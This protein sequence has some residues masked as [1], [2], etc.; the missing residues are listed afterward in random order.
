[1]ISCCEI[2]MPIQI[3][4][5]GHTL[6]M[7]KVF[8]RL[9]VQVFYTVGCLLNQ[10]IFSQINEQLVPGNVQTLPVIAVQ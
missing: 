6:H 9:L 8:H 5:Y 7:V 1:M 4:Q 2:G 10:G 3:L